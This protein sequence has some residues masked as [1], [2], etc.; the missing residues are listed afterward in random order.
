M[1][2]L[3]DLSVR[4]D[5]I[6][7]EVA[8]AVSA[9]PP[10][11]MLGR[12]HVVLLVHGFNN[13]FAEA[14]ESYGKVFKEAF[15]DVGFFFWPGDIHGGSLISATS[16]PYQI[17]SARTSAR[18]LASFLSGAFGPGGTPSAVSLITH[19]LGGRLVLEALRV[20]LDQGITW[21]EVRLVAMMAAAVPID[22][23]EEGEALDEPARQAHTL[24]VFY[25]FADDVLRFAFPAG[26][27]A[28]YFL[29]IEAANYRQ[30]VGRFGRPTGLTSNRFEVNW[31]HSGYW[32]S[33]STAERIA[34]LL[35]AAV[36]RLLP[37]SV[38]PANGGPRGRELPSVRATPLRR[39]LTRL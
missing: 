36:P 10:D 37:A 9:S 23:V 28:A 38:L 14:Q 4:V 35:G 34:G 26:Q 16:Y 27:W 13:T 18:R 24:A 33:Q 15:A 7:G 20:V 8:D 6:G 19:S 32:P 29:G 22:L 2:W 17:D 31:G 12:R 30:A 3:G 11:W 5:P 1:A 25:S 39:L 21:P